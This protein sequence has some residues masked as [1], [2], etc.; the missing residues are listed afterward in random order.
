MVVCLTRD[1]GIT[2]SSLTGNTVLGPGA[3]HFI[4]CLLKSRKTHPDMTE[5]ML[6]GR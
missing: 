1:Q 6:T 4:L 3:R 5:K 2:G